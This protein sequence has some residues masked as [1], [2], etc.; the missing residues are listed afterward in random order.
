MKKILYSTGLFLAGATLLGAA[1]PAAAP[2]HLEKRGAAT[3]LIVDG[4]PLLILGGEL[5][6]SSSSSLDYLKPIWPRLAAMNLNTVLA[7]VSWEL[8]EPAEGKY[9]FKL[10]DGMLADA[11]SNHLKLVLLWMGSWKNGTSRYAADWV[12]TDQ[13]RFPRV[14]NQEGKALEI[15][16]PL[17]PANRAADIRAY[18]TLMQHLAEVD[19]KDHTVLMIQMENEVG[20]LGA[21]RDFS[22]A[23]NAAFA[24]PVP[25]E[26]MNYLTQHKNNLS[27]E[28]KGAW[29]DAGDNAAGTWTKVF[30]S[31][32]TAD[33]IFMAWS[34]STYMNAV[35]AAGKAVY[36]LPVYVNAWIVQPEDHQPGD[37][38]SGGP[39]A[40]MHDIWRAGA[41]AID[42]L[43]PD[44]YLPDFPKIVAEYQR[45]GTPLFIPESRGG[46]GG[47]ANAFYAIGQCRAIG[48]SPFGIDGTDPALLVTSSTPAASSFSSSTLA[49]SSGDPLAQAYAVLKQLTPLILAHQADGGIAGIWL[50]STQKT[51][52]VA[53]GNYQ[54]NFSLRSNRRAPN[55]LPAQGYAMAISLGPDEYLVAGSDV[56][57]TFSPTTGKDIAGLLSVEEGQYVDGQWKPGRRLNGDEVQLGY[58]LSEEAAN[59]QSGAG[60]RFL[61]GGPTLQRVKLYR[62]R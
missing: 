29:D 25:V 34:Y 42:I 22:D 38:P 11:R 9:D 49:V 21:T 28:L 18:T 26:L 7:P 35:A 2:P 58:K 43:A 40:R 36:P 4:Q 59:G 48:Y 62:Y 13:A 39:Q 3:Q 53:L 45:S 46:V 8:I 57:V 47:A 5:H 52:S 55:D 16:S 12:K 41:P 1:T 54:L 15:L 44:I 33:E 27:P 56:Q 10:V 20:V 6:N 14:Q 37:Y 31:G 61:P 23:A 24:Q 32:V 17:S 30:G 60:L 19:G 50:N 51:Q